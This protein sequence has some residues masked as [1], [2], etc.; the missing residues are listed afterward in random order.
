MFQIEPVRS[1][2]AC[3]GET[4]PIIFFL[5]NI[6]A[7]FDRKEDLPPQGEATRA[8]LMTLLSIPRLLPWLFRPAIDALFTWNIPW[9]YRWRTLFLLQP[10]SLVGFAVSS[11]RWLFTQAYQVDYISVSSN[12]KRTIRI[13]VFKAPG[14]ENTSHSRASGLRPLHLDIHGGAFM[15]GW[16]EEDAVFCDQLARETGAVVISCGYRY[17]P[18]HVF[19]AAHDDVDAVVSYLKN[20]AESR[21]GADPD[22]FTVSGFSAGGNLALTAGS[23]SSR[24]STIKAAVTFYP[25]CDLRLKPH[26][27]PRPAREMKDPLEILAPLYDAYV[28]PV[29]ARHMDDPRMSPVLATSLDVLPEK[30]FVWAA[31]VD[32]LLQEQTEFVERVRKMI[33]KQREREGA[34]RVVEMHVDETAFHGYLNLPDS[35]IPREQKQKAFDPAVRFIKDVHVRNGYK[36]EGGCEI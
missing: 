16:P 28:D 15:A 32:I 26:E 25:V 17:A 18:R 9:R 3:V 23:T 31:G 11:A 30:I 10:L 6:L 29:R 35:I 8:N 12:P 27:K 33:R 36:W 7:L 2:G 21:Y 4:D 22:L 13:L 34:A 14:N 24:R 1:H 20:H 19:P 5:V